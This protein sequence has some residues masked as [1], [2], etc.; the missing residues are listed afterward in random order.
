MAE[1]NRV[2]LSLIPEVTP[3]VTPPAG[4]WKK[5]PYTAAPDFSFNPQTTQSEEIRADRQTDDLALVGIEAGGS[6]DF[7]LQPQNF[8]EILEAVLYNVFSK[9]DETDDPT[10]GTNKLTFSAANKIPPTFKPGGLI[11]IE[12]HTLHSGIEKLGA[13]TAAEIAI[14]DFAAGGQKEDNFKI[15][16][17][18]LEVASSAVSEDVNAKELEVDNSQATAI[19]SAKTINKG[20]WIG[21]QNLGFYRITKKA[22]QANITTLTYDKKIEATDATDWTGAL[23]GGMNRIWF[24]DALQNGIAKKSFSILQRFQS[25]A[26]NNQAVFSGCFA[27]RLSLAFETQAIITGSVNFLAYNSKFLSQLIPAAR[28]KDRPQ[29]DILNSSDD[30]GKI[31]LGDDEVKGPNFIQSGGLEIN[32]NSRRQNAVGSVGSIGIAAGSCDVTGNLSTYFGNTDLAQAV[33]DNSEKS[34]LTSFKTAGGR[35]LMFDLPRIKF[36][37]GSVG[38]PGRNEDLVLP[39]EFQALRE[40]DLGYQIKLSSFRYV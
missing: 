9:V 38:I 18:G 28:I 25:L 21:V 8:D 22:V 7:E 14:S 34:L 10:I 4:D 39:L 32:N 17:V 23:S 19:L 16:L 13:V 26:G 6:I 27:D 1:S 24:S 35:R 11:L 20:D 31:F 12:G 30:V 3:G 5:I 40:K 15:S 29:E 37:A 2:D 33:L 36:S